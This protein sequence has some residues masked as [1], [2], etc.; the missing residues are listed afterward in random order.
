MNLSQK[1][2]ARPEHHCIRRSMH[3]SIAI[4]PFI[5]FW[6][7]DFLSSYL[8]VN[9]NHLIILLVIAVIS[10]DINRLFKR[11][12]IISQRM[13]EKHV[14]SSMAWTTVGVSFVLLLAPRIGLHGAAIGVPLI[15]SLA[16]ADPLMGECRILNLAKSMVIAVGLFSVALVWISS[17]YFLGT[18]WQLIPFIVPITVASEV[19]SFPWIDDN[20]MMLLVPLLVLII[21]LH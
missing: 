4:F 8:N 20:A 17:A 2:L 18:P 12:L 9:I 3:L 6:Y 16:V 10:L 7:K 13:Y 15:L 11:K 1:V 19:I 21:V 14:I 5:Y